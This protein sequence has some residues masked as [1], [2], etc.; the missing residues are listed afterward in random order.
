M[1]RVG[2]RDSSGI[3]YYI[4]NELREQELGFLALGTESM[5]LGISIPP[6]ADRFVIDSYCPAILTQVSEQNHFIH[7]A[8]HSVFFK[9]IPSAG[10]TVVGA[11]PHTHLQGTNTHF[12]SHPYIIASPLVPGRSIWTKIIRNKT[13][14]RYLFDAES[15]DFNYQ[16]WN[17][18]P[19]PI[20]LYPVRSSARIPCLF[21]KD[22][23]QGDELLTRCVYSTTNK[24]EMTFVRDASNGKIHHASTRCILVS[25][26][27]IDT[28][29]DVPT[30]GRLLSSHEQ[31]ASVLDDHS[32]LG[33]G[34]NDGQLVVRGCCGDIH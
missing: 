8:A 13:V 19:E 18:L 32:T 26:W 10:I 27:R 11:F 25:G 22:A 34:K 17:T 29:R 30:L 14:V 20:K 15:Y 24:N 33:D 23:L 2:R 9:R 12:D 21:Q 1:T 3:R 5:D 4:G 6:R 7:V 28:A 31:S 16:F